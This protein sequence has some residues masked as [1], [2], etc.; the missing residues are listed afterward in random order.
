[1]QINAFKEVMHN[2]Y[3]Q[4]FSAL[5]DAGDA[6][7]LF[8]IIKKLNEVNEDKFKSDYMFIT[9]SPHPEQVNIKTFTDACAK[10]MTKPWIKKYLYVLEQRGVNMDELGSGI[11]FHALIDKGNYKFSHILKEFQSTF[12]RQPIDTSNQRCFNFQ[13]CKP[14]DLKKR[15]KYMVGKK[16]GEDKQLKQEFDIHFRKKYGFKKYYGE[17]FVEDDEDDKE[18]I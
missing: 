5:L 14:E 8:P 15:Q 1:M 2:K 18:I 4:H 3:K 6:N 11:H 10:A 9:I 13:L 17:L 12:R 7:E 16:A